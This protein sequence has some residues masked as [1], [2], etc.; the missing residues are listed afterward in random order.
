MEKNMVATGHITAAAEMNSSY[1]PG[2]ANVNPI[3]CIVLWG[4]FSLPPTASWSVHPFCT[5]HP[6]PPRLDR[7]IVFPSWRQRCC[8][9]PSRSSRARDTLELFSIGGWHYRRTSPCNLSLMVCFADVIVSQGTA[10]MY[11]RCGGIFS[12]HLTA[13][14][15]RNLPVKNV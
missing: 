7:S 5:S 1:L 6:S 2:G 11:A 9:P 10:A 12:I 8:R 14:L 15:P 3:Q 4:R 13:N